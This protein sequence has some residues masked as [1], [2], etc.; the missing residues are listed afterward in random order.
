MIIVSEIGLANVGAICKV[1]FQ[2][3]R[4]RRLE[5]G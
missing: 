1:H 2:G 5:S 4:V 3:S